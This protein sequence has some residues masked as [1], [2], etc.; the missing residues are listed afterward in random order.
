MVRRRWAAGAAVVLLIVIV[1]VINSC[2][3]SEKQQALKTYNREV[4]ALAQESD[5]QVSH[6][7]FVAL[8]DSSTKSALDVEQQVDEL[9]KQAQSI[10][11]HAKGL[12][13]PGGMAAAQQD[14]L[15]ALD[16]RVEGMTKLAA[17]VPTALGGQAKAASTKIAGDMEI[18]LASDVI[19]SQRVAPLIQ[20]TLSN[21]GIT[22]LTTTSTRFTP[23]VGWLEP[24]TVLAR[25][26]G[27]ASGGS[28]SSQTGLAPGTHGSALIGVSVGTTALEAEPTINH[29]GGGGNPT[30]TVTVEDSGEN[31]ETDVKVD[32]TVTAAGKQYKASRVINSMQAGSKTNVE[33]PVSNL[34]VGQPAKVEVEV[35]KVPGETDMENNK[36]SFLTILGE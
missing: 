5:A 2:V 22:G 16:L 20:Q 8:T 34:P 1:L 11:T 31:Q 4:S 12:S 21:A 35:E 19:Y 13:A 33:L 24:A 32:I 23:N 10:A 15:L 3:K 6:P 28:S 30:F 9:L 17:L 36:S 14:L 25:I 26:T 7:L 29:I 18:F 27:Q